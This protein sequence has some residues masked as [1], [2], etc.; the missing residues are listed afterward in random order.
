MSLRKIGFLILS[1]VLVFSSCKKDD[2][3]DADIIVVELRNRAEQQVIDN[4][5][6]IGYLETHYYNSGVFVDNSDPTITDLVITELA[7]GEAVPEGHTLLKDNIETHDIT[8]QETDYV[9]YIL[10]L[11]QGGGEKSPYFSDSVRVKY[12]GSTLDGDIFD[13]RVEADID[14]TST[15]FGWVEVMPQFKEMADFIENGDGTINFLNHGAGVM[16]IPSGLAY[17]PSSTNTSNSSL[18][19]SPLI[20]KFDL[21]QTIENDHDNDGVPSHLEDLNNDQDFDVNFDD[22]TDE[23]DDDTDGDGTP[24]YIDT[25]DDGDGV[26]TIYEDLEDTDLTFDS[27]GDGDPTNDKDG[28][29]DPTNDDT[30][31]DGIPN[32]L[33]TDDTGSNNL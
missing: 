26:L 14:L 9:Y 1:F 13:S 33:D 30:D 4:D 23:T 6:L 18:W 16:F 8:Y 25:D 28:D 27:D 7:A 31:G 11:N 20:F 32:Y 29:G 3:N 2:D 24:D 10:R 5:S 22:L 12:E 17:F 15:V 19:Y 21:L